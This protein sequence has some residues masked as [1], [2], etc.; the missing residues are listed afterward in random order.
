MEGLLLASHPLDE[1][2]LEL[3][4]VE[5]LGD[6]LL[7]LEMTAADRW[8]P[9]LHLDKRA[10]PVRKGITVVLCSSRVVERCSAEYQ[11]PHPMAP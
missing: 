5:Y 3:Q 4:G 9:C 7:A 11:S 8:Y 1:T 10:L 2:E 6:F